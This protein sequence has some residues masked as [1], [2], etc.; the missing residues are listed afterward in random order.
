MS[1]R[2][3]QHQALQNEHNHRSLGELLE[4]V[5]RQSESECRARLE[6]AEREAK[7]IVGEARRSAADLLRRVRRRERA[8]ARQRIEAE[9]A[10]QRSRLRQAWLARR[11]E[12]AE[13]GLETLHER[14]QQHWQSGAQA[15]R[16]WLQRALADA[17]SVLPGTEWTVCHPP[18]WETAEG[19]DVA[20]TPLTWQADEAL[21]AGFRIVAGSAALDTS[22]AGLLARRDRIA[23]HLLAGIETAPPELES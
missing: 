14:L 11:R 8:A 13:H 6:A 1:T 10:R 22:P 20:E 15:R 7:R 12:L 19:Q 21:V 5:E 9:N 3:T 16:G 4:H 17:A 2:S 23:G 18:S